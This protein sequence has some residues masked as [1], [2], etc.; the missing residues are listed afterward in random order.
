MI[1]MGIVELVMVEPKSENVRI[2]HELKHIYNNYI[3]K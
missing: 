2:R 3:A 1:Y